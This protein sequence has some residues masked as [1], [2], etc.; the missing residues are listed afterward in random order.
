MAD[1]EAVNGVTAANIEKVNGVAKASV[2]AVNGATTPSSGAEKWG[3]AADNAGIGYA[4]TSDLTSWTTYVTESSESTDY[5]T[6]AYG[7]DGSGNPLWVVGWSEGDQELMY[8]SDITN[9]SGFSDVDLSPNKTIQ[10]VHWGNNVWI[11]VG[12]MSGTDNKT[13]LRSTDG[14]SWSAI[15]V[16]SIDSGSVTTDNVKSVCSD[17][18]GNWLFSQKD[19]L[20]KSTDNGSN[21]TLAIDFNDAGINEIKDIQYT[22]STWVI[23]LKRTSGGAGSGP[24]VRTAASSDVTDWSAEQ[25]VNVGSS[26][27]RFACGDGKCLFVYSTDHQLAT[28]SGKTCTLA[29]YTANQLTSSI[30]NVATDGSGTFVAVGNSGDIEVTTDNGSN[31]TQ[32]VD[33]LDQPGTTN[34]KLRDVAAAVYL[35]V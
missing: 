24:Y 15:D 18:A 2:Q 13:I 11:A 12:Q 19:R 1:Y 35:P 31:W 5:K 21:W 25:D 6:I 22:N 28:V 33:G 10:S 20:Y 3:L 14:S 4:S 34:V 8:S 7:K 16:S 23:L 17:G 26:I 32:T 9:T 29:T 27:E 30:L